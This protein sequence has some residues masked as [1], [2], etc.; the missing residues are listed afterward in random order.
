MLEEAKWVDKFSVM[1]G[2]TKMEQQL[3]RLETNFELG[4]LG[5]KH[6]CLGEA[7]KISD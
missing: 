7:L 4:A 1:F 2:L 6:P 5:F 3:E